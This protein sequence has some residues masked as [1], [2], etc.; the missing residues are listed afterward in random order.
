[1]RI[2]LVSEHASP[3][4]ALGGADAGGQ[5]V[6]VAEQARGLARLGHEVVV[7]TRRDAVDLPSVASTGAGFTVEHVPAGPP[8]PVPKDELLPYVDAFG[9]HLADRWARDRPDVV[10]AH[11]WMSGV[12]SLA[13]AAGL[14]VPVVQTFHALGRVKRRNQ[15]AKDTSPP[16]REETEAAIAR[17]VDCVVATCSDE[18]AELAEMGVPRRRTAIVPCGIDLGKF[19]PDGPRAPR[20]DRPR[21]LS[22]GRLV[23]RKGVDTAIEALRYVPDAELLVAGG[24]RLADWPDDPE[25]ARLRAVARRSG[26]ADRVDF[27]G[28]VDH[29]DAPALYR[30]ADVVVSVP[31]YEPF[32]TVPLEAMACGVPPVVTAVGGHLDTVADGR[33]GLLVPPRDPQALADRLNALLARPTARAELGRAGVERVRSRYGWSGLVRDVEVVYRRVLAQRTASAPLPTGGRS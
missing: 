21:L 6:Q 10:H 5:N 24:P 20:R 11:F 8:E 28:P 22:I 2:H 30:S 29:D 12:A 15:G 4:A 14:D 33:T 27:L 16:E 23:E 13:G 17:E 9:R 18:V 19:T 1:M 7:H 32:G 3:L 31:W 26:V 25:V